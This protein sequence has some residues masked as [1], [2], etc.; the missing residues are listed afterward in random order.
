MED[1]HVIREGKLVRLRPLDKERDIDK[2]MEWLNDPEVMQFAGTITPVMRPWEEG[3]FDR[4]GNRPDDQMVFGIETLKEGKLIGNIGLHRIH[5]INRT[6]NS[7]TII[8]DK[9]YWGKGYGTDAKMLQL[10]FAFLSLN[11][12]CVGASVIA[13]NERSHRYL[14]GCGYKEE[15]RK[16]EWHY[17]N[18]KFYDEIILSV[19][20]EDWLSLWEKYLEELKSQKG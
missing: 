12:R 2:F 13:F 11:L 7:G 15:G 9:E 5:P 1:N 19:F 8:G 6:A 14:M 20:R 3:W 16:R 18:G 17:R 4:I 10:A